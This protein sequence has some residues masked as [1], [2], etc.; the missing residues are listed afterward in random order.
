MKPSTQNSI[1]ISKQPFI[2]NAVSA[3][4][5]GLPVDNS[6]N[7]QRAQIPNMSSNQGYVPP[8]QNQASDS[9]QFNNLGANVSQGV[10]FNMDNQ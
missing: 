6:A 4:K 1:S 8:A 9:V 2:Q 10:N 5:D 3:N 7:L